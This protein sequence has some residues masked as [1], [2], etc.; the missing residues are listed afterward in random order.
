MGRPS[1]SEQRRIEIG[2]ALQTCMIRNGSYESTSVKDIAQQAGIATGLVHHYFTSK[3]EILLLMADNALLDVSNVLEDI[4]HTRQGAARREKLHEL[5]AD[6]SQSR[7]ILMLYTLSLSMP[8]IKERILARHK[9]LE[10]ALAAR[11][12]SS[13]TFAGDP[14]ETAYELMFLLE[15]AVIQSAVAQTPSMEGLLARV[16]QSAFPAAEE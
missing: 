15:S 9:E 14:E 3:D 6:N 16:L 2:R 12:R 1:I 7:F 4:L 10:E 5:L 13:R 11:L 8:E